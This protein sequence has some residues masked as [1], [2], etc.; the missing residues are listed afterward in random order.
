MNS[1][2]VWV[3]AL[4]KNL[5]DNGGQTVTVSFNVMD[6]SGEVITTAEQVESFNIADQELAVGTQV[7]V[8]PRVRV[9]SVEPTLLIED[10]G[11]FE[12]TEADLGKFGATSIQSDQYDKST[13]HAK[14][15]IEN[16][17]DEVQKSPRIGIICHGKDGKINGGGSEFPELVPPSGQ[18]VLDPY[19]ITSGKPKTCTAYVAS[20]MVSGS[21]RRATNAASVPGPSHAQVCVRRAA[22]VCRVGFRACWPWAL[23]CAED[24]GGSGA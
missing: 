21:T 17:T 4:V 6:D 23:W 11:A 20:G 12:E 5:S 7:D 24:R 8:G 14:F 1:Q 22:Y 9:G 13:W 10:E 15:T 3:T 19:L 18:I 16:A 2:Y